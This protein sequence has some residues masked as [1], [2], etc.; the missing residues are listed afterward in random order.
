MRRGLGIALFLVLAGC[1]P[2]RQEMMQSAQDHCFAYGFDHGT[3]QFAQCMMMKDSQ[4][5][6]ME[7]R[8]RQAVAAGL[9]QMSRDMQPR[10]PVQMAP[11]TCTSSA[12]GNQVVTNCQ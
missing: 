8:R 2:S 1:G 7:F 5:Q 10:Q 3:P 9:Q 4:Y 11:R 12:I 6:D